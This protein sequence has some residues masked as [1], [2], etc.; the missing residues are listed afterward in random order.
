MKMWKESRPENRVSG[1]WKFLDRL[2]LVWFLHKENLI[3][4]M[5]LVCFCSQTAVQHWQKCFCVLQD[6]RQTRG[7]HCVSTSA[8][9]IAFLCA[10]TVHTYLLWTYTG[11]LWAPSNCNQMPVH[12]CR[13]TDWFYCVVNMMKVM[14]LDAQSKWDHVLRSFNLVKKKKVR[15]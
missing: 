11:L 9:M 4:W 7:I 3:V 8:A 2:W 14:W 6:E 1:I 12:K 5:E 13:K 15:K 10:H